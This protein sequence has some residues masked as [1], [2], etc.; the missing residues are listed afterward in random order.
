LGALAAACARPDCVRLKAAF[1]PDHAREEF[2]RQI[3][4][5]RRRFD[6]QAHRV[7]QVGPRALR[8]RRGRRVALGVFA[9]G[10]HGEGRQQGQHDDRNA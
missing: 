1:L 4:S 6:H 9:K 8:R 7:A 3:V 2:E 10:R 5:A